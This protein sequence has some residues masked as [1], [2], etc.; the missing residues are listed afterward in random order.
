MYMN[1]LRTICVLVCISIFMPALKAQSVRES[2]RLD[3]GWKFAFGHA[4][5]P[6]KDFGCG[7]EYFNYLT[8]ANSIH[9]E[10]PYSMK[11]NDADWQAVRIP[12]DWVATLPYASKASHS[13]GYKTVGHQ[14]PAT[15]VG[16]YRKHISIP[17]TDEGKRLQLRFDGIFR[18]AQVW[19]YG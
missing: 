11:F 12:H 6:A 10:G 19:L 2:V 8:K 9:N 14:Y 4:A 15:S 18:H 1:Q 3:D 17:K 16:W 5:E 7:T 13:H